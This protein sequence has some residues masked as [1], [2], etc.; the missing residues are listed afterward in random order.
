MQELES[1]KGVNPEGSLLI[2][3]GDI[4]IKPKR[5]FLDKISAI[6]TETKTLV[7]FS[8]IV[9]ILGLVVLAGRIKNS[10]SGF[11]RAIRLKHWDDFEE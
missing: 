1:R 6:S 3:Q 11:P 5:P 8:I 10:L 2:D 4:P 9:G 7:I